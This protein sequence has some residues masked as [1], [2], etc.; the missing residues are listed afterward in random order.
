MQ[1]IHNYLYKNIL[2][3]KIVYE[4]IAQLWLKLYCALPS[5]IA[6]VRPKVRVLM[7]VLG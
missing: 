7:G 3:T 1:T 4:M 6:L 5:H 2:A